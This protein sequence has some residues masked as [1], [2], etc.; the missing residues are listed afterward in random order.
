MER[1]QV[2]T[3]QAEDERYVFMND[4]SRNLQ[5]SHATG[6]HDLAA[7]AVLHPLFAPPI[8]RRDL[9]SADEHREVEVIA[10][11]EAGHAAATEFLPLFHAVADLDADRRQVPIQRLHAEAVIDDDAV[12]VDTQV[13]RVDDRAGAARRQPGRWR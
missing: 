10:A 11:G 4:G 7:D 2:S 12:A 1:E 13:R 5:L 8:H 9:L 6:C 3:S